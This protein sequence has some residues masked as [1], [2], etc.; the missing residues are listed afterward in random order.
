MAKIDPSVS[1]SE[2]CHP[3]RNKVS[4]LMKKV[5]ETGHKDID[6]PM[7]LAYCS[8]EKHDESLSLCFGYGKLNPVGE[9]AAFLTS[10]IGESLVALQES[11]W[12]ST[13]D[14]KSGYQQVE[15]A[16]L[17]RENADLT[18]PNEFSRS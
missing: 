10:Y 16:C 9:R 6:S 5:S 18:L 13:L 17:D 15:V 1:H 14:L 7:D 11:K 8:I 12:S 4:Y 2:A 3:P